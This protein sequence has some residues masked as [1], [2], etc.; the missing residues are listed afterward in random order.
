MYDLTRL[1]F[2]REKKN[3]SEVSSAD[4]AFKASKLILHGS[5]V[6]EHIG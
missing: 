5:T 6:P 2:K 1:N 3:I 4:N